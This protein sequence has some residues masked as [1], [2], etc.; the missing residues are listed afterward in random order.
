MA[1]CEHFF[2]GVQNGL[3]ISVYD[4]VDAVYV[5]SSDKISLIKVEVDK[6]KNLITEVFT[7]LE[8]IGWYHST[9]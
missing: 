1:S 6:K 5:E 8:L 7:Q 4:A 3:D 9:F 2:T